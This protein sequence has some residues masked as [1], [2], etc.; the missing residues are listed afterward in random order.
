MA[1]GY[2]IGDAVVMTKGHNDLS[3]PGYCTQ[4]GAD[5]AKYRAE[6]WLSSDGIN[7]TATHTGIVG[8]G[9][10]VQMTRLDDH[11]V[12]ADERSDAHEYQ[13]A[14]TD[15]KTWTQLKGP[16]IDTMS[17]LC[18][19]DQGFIV[20]GGDS[21]TVLKTFDSSLKLI[22][23]KQTGDLPWADLAPTPWAIG[24]TGILATDDGERF[25]IGVP[26]AG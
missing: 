21:G 20:G 2:V 17:L 5:R 3:E 8:Y 6:L 16:L 24:P 26:S 23:V 7:W 19:R 15:G 18:G 22:T 14:S 10:S 1:G 13:L 4:S 11:L 12:I 25:W 9:V